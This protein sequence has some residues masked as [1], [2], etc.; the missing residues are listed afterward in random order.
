[1]ETLDRNVNERS[2]K[3]RTLNCPMRLSA[4]SEY[5]LYT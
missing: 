1:M 3:G 5:E 2:L 4:L